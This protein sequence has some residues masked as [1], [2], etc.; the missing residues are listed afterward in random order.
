MGLQVDEMGLVA[1]LPGSPRGHLGLLHLLCALPLLGGWPEG[2]GPERP[3][4]LLLLG[5]RVEASPLLRAVDAVAV[6]AVGAL[7]TLGSD[8]EKLP[9]GLLLLL[10]GL[11]ALA[12]AVSALGVEASLL[13]RAVDAVSVR[14]VGAL[15]TLALAVSALGVEASPLLR[16]VEAV[17]GRAVGALGPD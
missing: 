13:L 4:G 11:S 16:A 10:L 1:P 12:L 6:R 2:E 8:I 17:S 7:V 3:P 15:V 14:A 5:L 9:P